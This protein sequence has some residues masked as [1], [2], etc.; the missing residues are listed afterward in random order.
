MSSD[1]SF[2]SVRNQEPPTRDTGTTVIIPGP[3][4]AD[5]SLRRQT[6]RGPPGIDSREN[7]A[8]WFLLG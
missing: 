7:K 4:P 3:E 8:R 1:A 2:H 5:T 6:R